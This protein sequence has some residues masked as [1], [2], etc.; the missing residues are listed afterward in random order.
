MIRILALAAALSTAVATAAHAGSWSFGVG[1][2][3][4]DPVYVEPPPYYY[5]PPAVYE[6]APP[7]IYSQGAAVARDGRPV[8]HMESADDVLDSLAR[9]GYREFSPIY[10][11]GHFY[12]VRAVDPNGDLVELEISIFTGEIV[13]TTVIQTRRG[14]PMEFPNG[15]LQPAIPPAAF[16]EAAPGQPPAVTAPPSSMRGRLVA[17]AGQDPLVVY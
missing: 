1:V 8:L 2:G 11:R 5:E 17:P 10:M 7:P 3:F 6:P 15:A 13:T 4:G 16:A 9:A 12:S 14:P